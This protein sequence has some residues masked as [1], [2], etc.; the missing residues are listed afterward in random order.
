MIFFY[1]SLPHP[2]FLFLPL[3]S[4]CEGHGVEENSSLQ[5][6]QL[7]LINYSILKSRYIRRN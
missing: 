4:L 2:L 7:P 6:N 1:V 5:F 3:K